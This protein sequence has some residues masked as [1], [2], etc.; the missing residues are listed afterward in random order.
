MAELKAL[1]SLF[2]LSAH[3]K[4]GRVSFYGRSFFGFSYYGQD[5]TTM[6]NGTVI[7]GV[8]R[9]RVSYGKRI[10][11]ILPFMYPSNPRTEEQQANRQKIADGVLTWKNLTEE[12]KSVYNKEAI[13][14]RMSGYNL[15]L[16]EY[17]KSN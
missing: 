11:E 16:S 6:E 1:E 12:E 13:G 7:S 5:K 8:F 15:F 14:K 10:K 3:K 9:E 17:L 4:I 2:S